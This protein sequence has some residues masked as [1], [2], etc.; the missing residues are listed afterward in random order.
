MTAAI[1]DATPGAVIEMR[2]GTYRETL[3]IG[4]AQVTI[5]SA[6]ADRAV[7]DCSGMVPAQ[8]KGCLVALR[9]GLTID[10]LVITGA[11]GGEGNEACL[12][13]EPD[14][15]VTLR[16][17]ECY[18]SYNGILAAGGDWVIEDSHFHDNGAGDGQTHNIYLS[19]TCGSVVARGL[20]S[21]RAIG[22]HAFKSRCAVSTIE[23]ST[24]VDNT[25]ADAAEF[26]DGGA[27]RIVDTRITQP[28][29]DN[30]NIVRHGAES[31]THG[32]QLTLERVTV[33]NE[34]SRGYIRS[35]CAPVVVSDSTIPASV[36]IS[37]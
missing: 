21:E 2:S 30:G 1:A 28:D 18:G 7:L 33:V 14:V 6:D 15:D 27:V 34:R 31:C 29:G 10:G 8:S 12:R 22:G 23:N 24:L 19:G 16:H 20:V 5:R 36:T 26:P 9:T 35:S 17:V 25:V 4:T 32:G 3:T 13:N 11:R 37:G